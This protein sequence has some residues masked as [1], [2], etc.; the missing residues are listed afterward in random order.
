MWSKS[1][2]GHVYIAYTL[3]PDYSKLGFC[4]K[5]LKYNNIIMYPS[6]GFFLCSEP[7]L[8][9]DGREGD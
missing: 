6:M 9:R 1:V 8:S 4:V 7:L 3:S 2:D 5:L